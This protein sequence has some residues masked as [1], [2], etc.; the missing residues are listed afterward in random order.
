MV[1]SGS[2]VVQFYSQKFCLPILPVICQVLLVTIVLAYGSTE[3]NIYAS[4]N[5]Y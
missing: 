4:A 2:S 5:Y 1:Q 3:C